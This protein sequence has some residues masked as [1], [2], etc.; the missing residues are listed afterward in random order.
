[1][2]KFCEAKKLM[3]TLLEI[4]I[5]SSAA[6]SVKNLGLNDKKIIYD[7]IQKLCFVPPR[8]DVKK[9]KRVR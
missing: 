3:N 5:T 7:A 4:V 8:G 6:K 9:T 2:G 1:M